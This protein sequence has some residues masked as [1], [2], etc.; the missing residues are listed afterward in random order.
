ML[1]YMLGIFVLLTMVIHSLHEYI[2]RG[3]VL[4]AKNIGITI[5]IILGLFFFSLYAFDLNVHQLALSDLEPVAEFQLE[6]IS[7]DCYVSHSNNG[8]YYI[9][10]DQSITDIVNPVIVDLEASKRNSP[11]VI[12]CQIKPSFLYPHYVNILTSSRKYVLIALESQI[13]DEMTQIEATP[14][15]NW[16]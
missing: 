7:P 12:V 16:L 6:E 1:W 5:S 11:T 13:E 2:T 8:K 9:K 14:S 15:P 10:Y 4:W 3:K